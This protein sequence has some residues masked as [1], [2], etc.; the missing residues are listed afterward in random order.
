MSK[1]LKEIL[2]NT[3]KDTS[4]S[5]IRL[6]VVVGLHLRLIIIYFLSLLGF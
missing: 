4:V 6:L 2:C 3:I 1:C 5:E